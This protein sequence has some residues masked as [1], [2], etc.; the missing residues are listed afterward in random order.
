V[1]DWSRPFLGCQQTSHARDSKELDL[2]AIALR[3][4]SV[5]TVVDLDVFVDRVRE[6]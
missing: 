5:K 6:V 2:S 4:Y 3:F 1:D